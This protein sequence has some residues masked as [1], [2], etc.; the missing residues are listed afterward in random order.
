[1]QDRITDA[2]V[3]RMLAKRPERD[4][5]IF[6]VT[7]PRFAFRVKPLKQAD[8]PRKKPNKPA[9]GAWFF[10]RYTGP[11]G[12]ETRV[13][14]GDP[15]TMTVDQ[16]RKAAKAALA[17]VDAGG[18]PK[19]Q[20]DHKRATKTVRELA[21]AYLA[22]PEFN[23]KTPKV[24]ANDRARIKDHILSHIGGEKVDTITPVIARR[25]RGQVAN[26]TRRNAR[27]RRLGGPGAARK[28]LRLLAA[29]FQWGKDAGLYASVPFSLR[30]LNLGG[31]GA[32]DAVITS[33]EEFARLFT[34]MSDLVA[35]GTLRQD[36]R[37]FFVLVASTGL[38]RG[39]AQ[40]LRWGQVN[41]ERRQITLTASNIRDFVR[42]P[43]ANDHC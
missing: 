31:D 26:D 8:Q 15:G 36:V 19:A 9:P 5:S 33:L 42:R 34:A 1:M 28:V 23:E 21:E 24:Q 35:A 12:R 29:L 40:G 39:E 6:D 22:S 10:I 13:K 25:L 18:D 17:V 3:R 43:T 30:E 20:Q 4:T 14:V 27:K 2:L 32:R 11:T 37:A 16:A 41:L 38:R 7:L